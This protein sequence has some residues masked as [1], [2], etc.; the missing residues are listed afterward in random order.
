M[1]IVDELVKVMGYEP[2]QIV[3]E[4][5]RE[6]Q[7]TAKGLSRS[8]QRLTTLRESLANLKSN[9]LEEKA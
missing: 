3:V 5:A 7:T 8:R 2:E 6:N 4:M 9:I 1:K